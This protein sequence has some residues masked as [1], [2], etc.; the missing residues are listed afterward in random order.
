MKTKSPF[1]WAGL[2]L[3]MIHS[4]SAQPVIIQRNCSGRFHAL[5]QEGMAVE[6]E[7]EV[8]EDG[9]AMFAEG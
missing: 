7:P 4:A 2:L 9:Q 6:S 8:M 3:G 1:F 5:R